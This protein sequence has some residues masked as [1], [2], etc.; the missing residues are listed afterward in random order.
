[1]NVCVYE[2]LFYGILGRLAPKTSLLSDYLVTN[3]KNVYR[4][5]LTTE[6]KN[7][8]HIENFKEKRGEKTNSKLNN[9]SGKMSTKHH[10]VGNL[11]KSAVCVLNNWF[12]MNLKEHLFI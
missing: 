6:D 11:F 1:M 8:T 10:P 5:K 4:F 12:F 3:K 7:N 2:A 9:A